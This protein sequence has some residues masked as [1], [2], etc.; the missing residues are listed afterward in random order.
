MEQ[1]QVNPPPQPTPQQHLYEVAKQIHEIAKQVNESNYRL[2]RIGNLLV[3][4]LITTGIVA[5][6]VIIVV[7]KLSEGYR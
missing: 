7:S 6:F 5:L 3:G 1:N 4:V 2:N